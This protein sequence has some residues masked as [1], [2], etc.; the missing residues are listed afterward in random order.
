MSSEGQ[1]CAATP[2]LGTRAVEKVVVG[3]VV[4]V[5]EAVEDGSWPPSP[6]YCWWET[7]S[8]SDCSSDP[9]SLQARRRVGECCGRGALWLLVC[10]PVLVRWPPT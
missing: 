7:D 6:P 3:V 4:V 1:N 5:V 10:R 9:C 8:F 2:G